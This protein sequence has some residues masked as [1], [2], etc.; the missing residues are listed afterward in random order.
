MSNE[1]LNRLKTPA[2]AE[3]Y[4]THAATTASHRFDDILDQILTDEN[5]LE[6][7]YALI[8]TSFTYFWYVK[9]TLLNDDED[10]SEAHHAR[11]LAADLLNIKT[12]ELRPI[13]HVI[14]ESD[15]DDV[16]RVLFDCIDYVERNF[17]GFNPRNEQGIVLIESE[18][19]SKVNPYLR[20]MNM[21]EDSLRQSKPEEA[22]NE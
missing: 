9:N 1:E 14:R 4:A 8:K 6:L 12:E 3:A 2:Y 11:E 17:D 20:F 18:L 16:Q 21:L 15:P 13:V 22:A 5:A 10:G 19:Y 7:G